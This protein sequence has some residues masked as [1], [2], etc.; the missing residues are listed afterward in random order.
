MS[1]N[2]RSSLKASQLQGRIRQ[3]LSIPAF[4]EQTV[5]KDI[6]TKLHLKRG[7]ISNTSQNFK[8]PSIAVAFTANCIQ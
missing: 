4:S 3:W 5:R 6:G 2:L 7:L 8:A 1:T